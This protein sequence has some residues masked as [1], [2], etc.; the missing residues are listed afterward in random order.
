MDTSRWQQ[1]QTEFPMMAN[2]GLGIINTE[3][4]TVFKGFSPGGED[5]QHVGV[6]EVE[7]HQAAS[8]RP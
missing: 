8:G 1:N 2:N 3:V 6:Q 5:H 4:I 7:E